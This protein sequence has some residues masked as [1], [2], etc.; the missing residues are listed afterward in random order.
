MT[1]R[2]N[3][4]NLKHFPKGKSGNPKGRPKMPDVKDALARVLAEEKDGL[5]ALDV[6][7]RAL[8]MKATRGDVRAAEVLLDRAF[9]KSRQSV[10]VNVDLSQ[11]SDDE[12]ARIAD[13]KL[14]V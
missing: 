12:L 9:G 3:V 14:P 10:D 6:V 8:R 7:F 4:A 13:G 11:M 2:G 5:T 1:K